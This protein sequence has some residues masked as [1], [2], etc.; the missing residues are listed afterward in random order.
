MAVIEANEKNFDELVQGEYA[1]VDF[2]GDHCGACVFTAPYFRS[3][4]DEMAFIDFIKVN[5]SAYPSLAKRF[6]IKSLPT[7][8][9][10]EKGKPVHKSIGGMDTKMINKQIAELLYGKR[11]F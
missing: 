5:T 9:Y 7:F 1:V 10:F 11:E 8:I 3:A 4:S 2:Y 6:D